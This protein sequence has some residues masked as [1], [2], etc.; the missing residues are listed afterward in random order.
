ML[1]DKLDPRHLSIYLFNLFFLHLRHA[2]FS[3]TR[4]LIIAKPL[5]LQTGGRGS[6]RIPL[7]YTQGDTKNGHLERL[8]KFPGVAPRGKPLIDAYSSCD[9]LLNYLATVFVF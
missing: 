1:I 3:Q 9:L 5:F 6:V 4:V 7:P 8:P 2:T